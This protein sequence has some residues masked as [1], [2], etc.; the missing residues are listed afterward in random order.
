MYIRTVYWSDQSEDKL[1]R[2]E[3][4]FTRIFRP[5]NRERECWRL[6]VYHLYICTEA[7]FCWAQKSCAFLEITFMMRHRRAFRITEWQRITIEKF[8][9]GAPAAWSTPS[10]TSGQFISFIIC[11]THPRRGCITRSSS[12]WFLAITSN[13]NAQR[14]LSSMFSS[15][16]NFFFVRFLFIQNI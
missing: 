1:N 3:S 11:V 12:T 2:K 10:S 5:Q 15:Q 9:N 13:R 7:I 4:N 16:C 14:W 6:R 8:T